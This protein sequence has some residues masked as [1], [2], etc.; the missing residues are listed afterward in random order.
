[1]D[2][3]AGDNSGGFAWN[4]ENNFGPLE[5]GGRG[6]LGKAAGWLWVAAANHGLCQPIKPPYR[7][8]LLVWDQGVLETDRQK[9]A[10][11]STKCQSR[12][13]ATRF[14]RSPKPK[15]RALDRDRLVSPANFKF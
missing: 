1:M 11:R 8:T 5:G 7:A 6:W 2:R 3:K 12:E 15:G 13:S 14:F 4:F 10:L 9:S